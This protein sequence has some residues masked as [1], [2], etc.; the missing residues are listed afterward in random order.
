[1]ENWRRGSW[2]P[3]YGTRMMVCVSVCTYVYVCVCIY[4][5]VYVCVCV[6]IV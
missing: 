4:L 5:C 6:H 3:W 2:L 1:M